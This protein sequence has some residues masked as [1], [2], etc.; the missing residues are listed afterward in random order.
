M[1]HLRDLQKL[2]GILSPSHLE[3]M[4][5]AHSLRQS[6]VKIKIC[7]YSHELLVQYLQKPQSSKMFGIINEHITF[8]VSPGQPSS[9]SDETE[10]VTLIGISQDTAKQIMRKVIIKPHRSLLTE[11][12]VE[13]EFEINKN[14][15]NESR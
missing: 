13:S 5:F 9:I 14:G 12:V 10:V 8:E 6:K 15:Y 4:E 1:M 3:E 7:Q 11:S 2:E